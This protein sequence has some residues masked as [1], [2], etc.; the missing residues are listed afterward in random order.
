[1]RGDGRSLKLSCFLSN[2]AERFVGE[3]KINPGFWAKLR[4]ITPGYE[5]SM[6]NKFQFKKQFGKY[7][8]YHYGSDEGYPDVEYKK[9]NQ[10]LNLRYFVYR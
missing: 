10:S 1:L 7:F 6:R 5:E 4:G 2:F 9:I 8:D 3:K